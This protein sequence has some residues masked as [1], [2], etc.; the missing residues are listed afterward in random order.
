MLSTV[1]LLTWL[2]LLYDWRDGDVM[3]LDNCVNSVMILSFCLAE[4]LK[5]LKS[6]DDDEETLQKVRLDLCLW[7]GIC[8]PKSIFCWEFRP[9]GK[10]LPMWQLFPVLKDAFTYAV[11]SLFES[12][13]GVF[14]HSVWF[15]CAGEN[16]ADQNDQLNQHNYKMWT[17]IYHIFWV[18]V[19]FL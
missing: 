8:L 11:F 3:L 19:S 13:P 14:S 18:A 16:T 9:R 2:N 10:K 15:V 4:E 7:T 6:A 5:K 17:I 1:T 12:S